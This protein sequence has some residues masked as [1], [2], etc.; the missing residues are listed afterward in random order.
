[1]NNEPVHSLEFRALAVRRA[2]ESSRQNKVAD[3][4]GIPRVKLYNWIGTY[5]RQLARGESRQLTK[6]MEIELAASRKEVQELKQELE[7]IKKAAAYFAKER[8]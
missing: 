5:R 4:L 3:D 1:M 8:E 6:Q 7:I 2:L